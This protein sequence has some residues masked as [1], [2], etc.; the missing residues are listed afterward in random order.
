MFKTINAHSVRGRKVFLRVDWNVPLHKGKVMDDFRIRATIPTIKFLIAHGAR[1]IIGTHLGDPKKP[2][3]TLSTKKLIPAVQKYLKGVKVKFAV[4]DKAGHLKDE[5]SIGEIG[6]LEN[7]RFHKGEK[8]NDASFAKELSS[9][10]D[11]YVNDAFGAT[12]RA[13]ASIVG[14]PRYLPCY[15][16]LLLKKEVDALRVVFPKPKRPLT[17]IMGGGKATS[18]LKLLQR[19]LKEAD[20]VILG[21]VL[22]NSVLKFQGYSVGASVVD[23]L[24]LKIIK[25]NRHA[26]NKILLPDDFSVAGRLASRATY[27]Y[28]SIN[29]IGPKDLLLDIGRDSINRFRPVIARSKTIVWNGPMG[30]YEVPSFRR[31]TEVLA[32]E[33]GK[34]K[35]FSI[36]GG[37]DLTAAVSEF[38][39]VGK[40]KHIST[41]GGAMLEFLAGEKLPGLKAL[42]YY[43]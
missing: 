36:L 26:L 11:I 41:G 4:R 5:I 40:F 10:A 6:V 42:G 27:K 2:I 9:M 3:S 19:V 31:G 28:K 8:E 7:L 38:P 14:V 34:S 29:E 43:S 30:F 22:A 25:R 16:G 39:F 15:A 23:P 21:G 18:K 37:G 32:W 24:A 12:H 35:A 33:V 20:Y 13:H 17:F 1:I